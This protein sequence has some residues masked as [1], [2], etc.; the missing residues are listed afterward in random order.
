MELLSFRS[1]S[2]YE[3][4]RRQRKLKN[5][6]MRGRIVASSPAG[7]TKKLIISPSR[8]SF[9]AQSATVKNTE[10][11]PDRKARTVIVCGVDVVNKRL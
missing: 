3:Y 10:A 8:L 6:A 9:H 2:R 5:Q 11:N 7:K 1:Y 4:I